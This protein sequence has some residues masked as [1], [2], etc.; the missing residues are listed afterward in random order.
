MN[1]QVD[2]MSG[3]KGTGEVARFLQANG[4]LDPNAMRPYVDPI[5]GNTFVTVF[6]GGD[7]TKP[8]NYKAI[9]VN[10]TGTLR[11]DEWKQLDE[12][13]IGVTRERLSGFDYLIGKGLVYNLPNA[14]GTTVLEWHSASDSQEAIISMDAVS[15]GQGDRSI[16]KQH[17]LPIPILHADYEIN[18]RV[19]AVARNSGNGIDASEAEHAA[20]RIM[21]KKEDMLFTNTTYSFGDKG[22]DGRNTIYSLVNYPDRNQ[23]TLTEAWNASGKT[24]AEILADVVAMKNAAIADRFYGPYTL[25]IPTLYDAIL[26]E[27]YSVS[28]ASLMTTRERIM[29]IAGIQDIKV[30]DHLAAN[31]V[32]LVQTTPNVVRIINGL[33]LQNIEWTTEGGMV[34]KYKVMTIQVPQIRSTYDSKCGIVHLA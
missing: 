22:T 31:N 23:V 1:T 19:L 28:G 9:Q 17:F 18:T 10:Y 13:V 24:A 11:P 26:D 21:E 8:E 2:L 27:D 34:H 32:L 7:K 30:V 33:P 14:M 4:K 12:A 6:K 3:G 25:F 29:K 16:F 15:R 20:R 5:T